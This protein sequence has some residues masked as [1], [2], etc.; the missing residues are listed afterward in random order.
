MKILVK[1]KSEFLEKLKLNPTEKNCK[2]YFALAN[3]KTE[4]KEYNTKNVDTVLQILFFVDENFKTHTYK[5]FLVVEL[6][7]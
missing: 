1:N 6:S 4:S 7:V 2:K 5:D 3:L